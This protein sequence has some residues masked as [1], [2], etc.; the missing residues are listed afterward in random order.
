MRTLTSSPKRRPSNTQLTRRTPA[1]IAK[2][3]SNWRTTWLRSR[4]CRGTWPRTMMIWRLW[5][6][7]L[8]SQLNPTVLISV[9][10]PARRHRDCIS[11]KSI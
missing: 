3:L 5:R 10:G 8:T 4:A 1:G 11:H 7:G 6:W 2:S 9:K